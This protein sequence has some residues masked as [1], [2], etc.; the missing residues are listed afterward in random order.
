MNVRIAAAV[1]AI[2]VCCCGC[3]KRLSPEEQLRRAQKFEHLLT[4]SVELLRKGDAASLA[5]AEA[6]VHLAKELRGSDPRVSDAL[7]CIAWRRQQFSTAKTYFR[8][9]IHADSNYARA[10]AHYA[11]ALHREGAEQEAEAYFREAIARSPLDYRSRAN[12]AVF[13]GT[14]GRLEEAAVETRKALVGAPTVE[15]W[16]EHN[17]AIFEK[18]QSREDLPSRPQSPDAE[19]RAGE[20]WA[21]E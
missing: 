5:E 13:L 8:E 17:V 2:L 16:L 10:Y 20:H 1:F 9:A 4:R 14:S 3:V 12:F 19:H 18:R 6:A 11:L 21:S 7:G 15:P